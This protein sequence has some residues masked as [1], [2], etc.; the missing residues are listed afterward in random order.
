[1]DRLC[2]DNCESEST[3]VTQIIHV[4]S[5]IAVQ[6]DENTSITIREVLVRSITI[7]QRTTW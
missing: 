5:R 6:T 3:I 1:M 2:T 4:L 7:L